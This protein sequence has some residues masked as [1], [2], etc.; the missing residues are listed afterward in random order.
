MTQTS[1]SLRAWAELILLAVIWSASFLAVRTALDEI[2]PFTA[3]LWRIGLAAVLLALWCALRGVPWPPRRSLA[4]LAVMG[5]MNTALPFSLLAWGQQFISTG[6][7]SIL[8]AS[9]AIFGV[10]AAALLLADE[11]LTA[12]RAAGVALGFAGVVT[13]I[14]PDA[15]L[16]FDLT[17]AAQLAVLGATLCYA[18]SGV[19]ARK[20]LSGLPPVTAA[21]G[22]LTAATLVMVPVTLMVEGVPSV[23]L[24]PATLAGI[25]YA[26]CAS[27][28]LAYLL[29]YRVLAMAGSGNLLLVTL[30][31]PPMAIALGALVRDEAL[32][33]Q[34]FAGLALLATGL[35]LLNRRKR[36]KV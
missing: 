3:V 33:P 35:M 17:S 26:A 7:T 14:G 25:L 16:A 4:P 22:M 10:L 9:T 28:A 30:L 19:W 1:L 12:P 32:P 36:A 2:G 23:A 21:L 5:V 11:R 15:L 29:Y 34:A 18:L 27:T 20:R 6:L 8:N 31:I 24:Q 13:V